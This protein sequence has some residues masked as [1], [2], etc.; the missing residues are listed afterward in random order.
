MAD[1]TLKK[2]LRYLIEGAAAITVYRVLGAMP[3]PWASGLG[4]FV[5]RTFGPRT[6]ATRRA[7]A[8]LR[9][10]MPELDESQIENIVR[11]MW[12]NL[13]R[14]LAEYPHL[15]KF[16]VYDPNG[17]IEAVGYTPKDYPPKPGQ[18]Y[19]FWSG[20]YGNWEIATLAATQAGLKAAAIYRAANNPIVD[21]LILRAR[22]VFGSE[23]IPKG[24][25]GRRAIAA[26]HKG[27]H[28]CLLIDQ[29]MNSGIPV[30]F[31]G[32]D[33]MTE[34]VLARLALRYDCVVIPARVER[35]SGAK[36]RLICDPPME[37]PR[38]GDDDADALSLMTRI[39]AR[40]EE[41][42]R[43]RPEQWFWLHRRW[44]E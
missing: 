27:A 1:A 15:G 30:P 2:R 7:R 40:L 16:E 39:N 38:T 11:G 37:V 41:W 13:G 21:R 24:A 42:I 19:L 4:G 29:K 34:K 35:I 18:T 33:A 43:E 32:R 22:G 14:V 5:G 44:P 31:F 9:H 12:E 36:F 10:A 3:L 6:G 28:L 17:R 25:T 23:L 20:H 8:N 26:L